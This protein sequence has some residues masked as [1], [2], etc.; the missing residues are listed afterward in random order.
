MIR[1]RWD[2]REKFDMFGPKL[3]KCYC[4]NPDVSTAVREASSCPKCKHYEPRDRPAKKI[5]RRKKKS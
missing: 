1:C 5:E 4:V 3:S 2:F